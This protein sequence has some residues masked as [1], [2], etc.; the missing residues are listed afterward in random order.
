MEYAIYLYT[1]TLWWSIVYIEGVSVYNF[2]QNI[3]ID[4][5]L[6]LG[7]HMLAK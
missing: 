2:F 5:F 3:V 1:I 6:Y 4:G 7:W